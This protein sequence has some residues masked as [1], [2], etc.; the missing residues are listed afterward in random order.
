M[1]SLFD[2]NVA[3]DWLIERESWFSD[4]RDSWALIEQRRVTPYLSAVS[5]TN[6]HYIVRRLA[7]DGTAL[8]IV[9]RALAAFAI[10]PVDGR[11][12]IQAPAL[13][14]YDYEDNVQI[15]CASTL[16]LDAIVTRDPVGFRSS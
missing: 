12:L 13:P 4:A 5:V 1:E 9:R 2:T 10:V 11:T 14:G 3:L 7:D 15:A 8:T 16:K 6:M